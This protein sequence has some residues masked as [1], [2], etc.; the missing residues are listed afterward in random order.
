M[1]KKYIKPKR[2]GN[3]NLLKA[4]SIGCKSIRRYDIEGNDDPQTKIVIKR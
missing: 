1:L 4:S 3:K 2:P